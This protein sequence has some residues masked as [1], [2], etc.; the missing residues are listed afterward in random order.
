M[1]SMK[2]SEQH[3]CVKCFEKKKMN[4]NLLDK[5]M[6]A[7]FSPENTVPYHPFTYNYAS[8][9]D[10][11]SDGESN[12]SDDPSAESAEIATEKVATSKTAKRKLNLS[13]PVPSPQPSKKISSKQTEI[14]ADTTPP[15][16]TSAVGA[17][18]ASAV[19]TATASGES[20][21]NNDAEDEDEEDDGIKLDEAVM[22]SMAVQELELTR[23]YQVISPGR[24]TR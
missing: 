9:H 22:K 13:S 21:A 8:R 15:P 11:H 4:A 23:E 18:A 5:H 7:P 10:L 19:A 12:Y 2:D 24:F 1:L 3:C 20:T 6:H 17:A 16:A 14:G